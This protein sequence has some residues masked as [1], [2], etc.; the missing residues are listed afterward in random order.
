MSSIFYFEMP[1]RAESGLLGL[2][3]NIGLGRQ[4]ISI[5]A[6]H[7]IADCSHLH[8]ALL[9]RTLTLLLIMTLLIRTPVLLIIASLIT[10]TI[11][12]RNSSGQ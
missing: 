2:L 1:R 11:A 9:T 8:S 5:A 7:S 3:G 10:V 4:N 6:D 12:D